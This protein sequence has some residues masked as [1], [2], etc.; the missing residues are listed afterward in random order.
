[1]VPLSDNCDVTNISSFPCLLSL[2]FPQGAQLGVHF[3]VESLIIHR[4]ALLIKNTPSKKEGRK[5]K[6]SWF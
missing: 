2:F 4:N 3:Q 6:A 1:M 5:E